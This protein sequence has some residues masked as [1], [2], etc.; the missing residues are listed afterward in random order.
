MQI[1]LL[2]ALKGLSLLLMALY[3]LDILVVI[4]AAFYL[5][6]RS[7]LPIT[8]ATMAKPVWIYYALSKV[9]E[10]GL[11]VMPAQLEE[12][13]FAHPRSGTIHFF[14]LLAL[15]SHLFD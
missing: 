8:I 10:W 11:G 9:K 3:G 2:K 5:P 1:S 4:C 12:N 6:L 7:D 14:S 15:K 13:F